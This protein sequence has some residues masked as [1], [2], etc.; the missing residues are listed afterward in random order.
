MVD[1]PTQLRERFKIIQRK[2]KIGLCH[3]CQDLPL[4]KVLYKMDG[5][6]LVEYFCEKHMDKLLNYLFHHQKE[7]SNY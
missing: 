6:N 7:K 5:I 3:I 4:Y 2:Y 1:I